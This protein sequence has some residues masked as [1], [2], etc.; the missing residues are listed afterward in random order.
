[1]MDGPDRDDAIGIPE[2]RFAVTPRCELAIPIGHTSICSALARVLGMRFL[3]C[4]SCSMIL[5]LCGADSARS[6]GSS[7]AL[8]HK[9]NS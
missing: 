4:S 7:S 3:L 6:L 9:I 2:E 8:S 5:E 1:M